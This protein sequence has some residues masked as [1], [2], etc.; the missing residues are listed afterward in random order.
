MTISL[1]P[2]HV[3]KYLI[4]TRLKFGFSKLRLSLDGPQPVG[5]LRGAARSLVTGDLPD[6]KAALE[7]S[8][9]FISAA[10]SAFCLSKQGLFVHTYRYS[11]NSNGESQ[12]WHL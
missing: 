2:Q 5:I 9:R 11:T 6:S 12:Y 8:I 7:S 10:L 4:S 3:Q 1:F